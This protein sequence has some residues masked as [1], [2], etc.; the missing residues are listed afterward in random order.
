MKPRLPHA[1]RTALIACFATAIAPTLCTG[2]I[3]GG[4]VLLALTATPSVAA[5]VTWDGGD[6]TDTSWGTATN[7]S[8]DTLPKSSDSVKLGGTAATITV[9]EGTTN[10]IGELGISSSYTLTG[11]GTLII[12]GISNETVDFDITAS[13]ATLSGGITVE[14]AAGATAGIGSNNSLSVK[15]GSILKVTDTLNVWG[16]ASLNVSNEATAEITTL[17][18]ANNSSL[19][20]NGSVTVGSIAKCDQVNFT[21]DATQV[22]VTEGRGD[23][24]APYDGSVRFVSIGTGFSWTLTNGASLVFG[25]KEEV[26]PNKVFILWS[27]DASTGATLNVSDSELYVGG[28]MDMKQGT[29][30][31][32]TAEEGKDSTVTVAGNLVTSTGGTTSAS[33]VNFTGQGGLVDIKGNVAAAN[34]SSA[35]IGIVA[36]FNLTDGITM[37]VGGS[38]EA[39]GVTLSGSTLKVQNGLT[40]S[41]TVN[42]GTGSTLDLEA[43]SSAATLTWGD[44]G[45]VN[46]A[47]GTTFTVGAMNQNTSGSFNEISGGGTLKLTGDFSATDKVQLTVTGTKLEANG[48][49]FIGSGSTYI[50]LT[51]ARNWSLIQPT[52][53]IILCCGVGLGSME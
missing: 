19:T 31:N 22:T 36:S 44:N 24:G 27:W 50:L 51:T 9:T 16:G 13:P 33:T 25:S 18:I 48:N 30:L 41:G 52:A 28:N 43:D 46:V 4:L 32:V 11:K 34:Y 42:L 20:G 49:L 40:A 23:G 2:A 10:T 15:G 37:Q 21:I 14:V 3:G 1:L 29:T 7:W 26:D 38:M 53:V 5:E 17:N 39:A 6:G 35:N 12:S 47:E 45:T 8:D